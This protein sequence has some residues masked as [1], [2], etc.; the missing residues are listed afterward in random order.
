MYQKFYFTNCPIYFKSAH[1][2]QSTQ[3]TGCLQCRLRLMYKL[4]KSEPDCYHS[5]QYFHFS[6]SHLLPLLLFHLLSLQ[7]DLHLFTYTSLFLFLYHIY[8]NKLRLKFVHIHCRLNSS[9]VA[10]S[11]C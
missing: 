3:V 2:F 11:R 10:C 6:R 9:G 7:H 5:S 4:L 8:L 1:L